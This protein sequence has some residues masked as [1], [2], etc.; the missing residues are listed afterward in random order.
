MFNP[1]CLFF[2]PN[3]YRQVWVINFYELRMRHETL[4]ITLSYTL[5]QAQGLSFSE[6]NLLLTAGFTDVDTLDM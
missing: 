6:V 5:Y 2:R 1:I 3:Q 4:K